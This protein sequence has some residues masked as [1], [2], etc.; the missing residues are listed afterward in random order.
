MR[1]GRNSPSGADNPESDGSRQVNALNILFVSDASVFPPISGGRIRT[2]ALLRGL[3]RRFRVDYLSFVSSDEEEASREQVGEITES[4]RF[5]RRDP[6]RTNIDLF[7]NIFSDRAITMNDYHTYEMTRALCE[8]VDSADYDLVILDTLHLAQYANIIPDYPLLYSSHNVESWILRRLVEHERN[9][10]KRAYAWLL[11]AKLWRQEKQIWRAVDAIIAVSPLD[12]D[13]M[14]THASE[15]KVILA[16]NG[17]DCEYY[18]PAEAGP[19]GHRLVYVGTMDWIPNIDAVTWFAREVYPLV[20]Q[21]IGDATFK[22]VGANPH[23]SVTALA[24]S[25]PSITVTGRVEDTRPHIR[26]AALNVVPLR[27][28]GG[29]RLKILETFALGIPCVSTTVGCE[30]LELT[31][32][33]DLLVADTPAQ[34]ADAICSALTDEEKW[35]SLR[36]AG[37][38]TARRAY[39][40]R[41]ITNSLCDEIEE[42]VA[43]FE[44]D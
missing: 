6:T 23:P 15:Q 33:K 42:F 31:H 21:R 38:E 5:V 26:E 27:I 4:V 37:L 25:D 10:G 35:R 16:P 44:T 20:K 18:Q 17:V 8:M 14:K 36:E 7:M 12:R 29:S 2:A 22:I 34:L 32:G 11:H 1:S 3:A 9:L 39:D 24:D 28:G 30:G 41:A 40:W 19:A 13:E 43:S